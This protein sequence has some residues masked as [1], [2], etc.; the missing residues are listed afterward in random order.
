[1]C[2][3]RSRCPESPCAFCKTSPAFA[4]TLR[5]PCFLLRGGATCTVPRLHNLLL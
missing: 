3:V 4:G 5:M 2:C 1:V